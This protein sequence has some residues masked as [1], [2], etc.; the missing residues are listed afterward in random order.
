[1]R[2]MRRTFV[3]ARDRHVVAAPFSPQRERWRV[4]GHERVHADVERYT[5]ARGWSAAV[6]GGGVTYHRRRCDAKRWVEAALVAI[7]RSP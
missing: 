6:K 4:V 5:Y 7:G 2:V 3:W 1:M